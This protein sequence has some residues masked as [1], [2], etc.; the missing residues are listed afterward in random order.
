MHILI[1]LLQ[2]EKPI[3]NLL[4]ELVEADITAIGP[5]ITAILDGMQ[6]VFQ[7]KTIKHYNFVLNDC[8]N[9]ISIRI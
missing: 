4:L 8:H 6:Y 1:I 2:T 7:I 5:A 9:V 3:N